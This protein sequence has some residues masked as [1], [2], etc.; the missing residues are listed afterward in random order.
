MDT[1]R[2]DSNWAVLEDSS[3]DED[4]KGRK[5]YHDDDDGDF[6]SKKKPGSGKKSGSAG[7]SRRGRQPKSAAATS[8]GD[9][10]LTNAPRVKRKYPARSSARR[11]EYEIPQEEY[12]A[13]AIDNN[14]ADADGAGSRPA[15]RPKLLPREDEEVI[16]LDDD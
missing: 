10:A 14:L 1:T 12:N 9:A 16:A 5:K 15:K 2:T 3:S 8:G 7:G 6:R 11:G 13:D 4:K